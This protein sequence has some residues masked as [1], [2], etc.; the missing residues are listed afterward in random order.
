MATSQLIR[1]NHQLRSI[2]YRLEAEN[3]ALKGIQM[4]YSPMHTQPQTTQPPPVP[5]QQQQQQSSSGGSTGNSTRGNYPAIAPLLPTP[6]PLQTP[7]VLPAYSHSV[8]AHINSSSDSSMMIIPS[9]P[10]PVNTSSPSPTLT[11]ST[12]SSKKSTIKPKAVTPPPPQPASNNQPLE[13]TFA[14]ST[15]ASLK[16]SGG[17]VSNQYKGARVEPIELVQL[18][19]PG[20]RQP[21]NN[22]NYRSA[23]E[24]PSTPSIT[25]PL[26]LSPKSNQSHTSSVNRAHSV[27][28]STG[29]IGDGE[30]SE[31]SGRSPNMQQ[32]KK[33]TQLENDL[34]DCHIDV[35][36]Q[37]FCERL[38]NEVCNDA[39]DRLLSEPLFDQM[40]KLNLSIGN[41]PVPIVTGPMTKL[42]LKDDPKSSKESEKHEQEPKRQVSFLASSE[43]K[44]QHQE[45]DLLTVSEI[46]FALTQHSK[47]KEFSTDQ[48]CQAVKELAKCADGGPVLEED[49]LY[50]IIKRMDKGKL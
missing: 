37:L 44:D 45:R 19:P 29:S 30:S 47:F 14:I 31:K 12:T 39:F 22:R 10:V 16:P 4:P 32:Q 41:Y 33:I 3:Y 43:N 48:L 49:D 46:W 36:G 6:G 17:T 25:D 2:I 9:S 38:H 7:F 27:V 18:Y 26:L 50:D 11:A 42:S 20:S 28:S 24:S 23:S 40:G 8:S 5:V 13:Y 21:Q 35:E 34:F 15:P 1:E